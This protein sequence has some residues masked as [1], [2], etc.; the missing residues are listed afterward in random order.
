MIS[1]PKISIAGK[2]SQH[3]I[4]W[5]HSRLRMPY[6]SSLAVIGNGK[7]HHPFPMKPGGFS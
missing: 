2:N 7:F 1:A 3:N 4:A 5:N 6:A